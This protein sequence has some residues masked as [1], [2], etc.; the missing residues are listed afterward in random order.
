[1]KLLSTATLATAVVA[2][3]AM[4]EERQ[5]CTYGFVFARGSTEPS[6]LVSIRCIVLRQLRSNL[7]TNLY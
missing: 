3:P 5:A 2:A 1:M 4:L 6:P 7:V